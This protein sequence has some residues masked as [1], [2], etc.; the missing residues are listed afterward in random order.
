MVNKKCWVS[1]LVTVL[2]LGI[3][4]VSCD[5][6]SGSNNGDNIASQLNGNWLGPTFAGGMYASHIVFTGDVAYL[7]DFFREDWHI[8]DTE[9]PINGDLYLYEISGNILTVRDY[10]PGA[11]SPDLLFTRVNGSGRSGLWYTAGLT[12]TNIG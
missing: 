7:G 5:D 9:I 1:I 3:A 12:T 2:V 10:F 6:T 8:Q 11:N 4:V